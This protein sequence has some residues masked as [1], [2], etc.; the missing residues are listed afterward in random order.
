MNEMNI[1]PKNAGNQGGGSPDSSNVLQKTLS[2]ISDDSEVN[3]IVNHMDYTR[4]K[5]SKVSPHGRS[6]ED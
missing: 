2:F 4:F 6:D 5:S 3:G 1:Q